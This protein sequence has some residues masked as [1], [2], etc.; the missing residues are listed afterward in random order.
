[1]RIYTLFR[2][3]FLFL[4]ENGIPIFSVLF[5]IH[6][7]LMVAFPCSCSELIFRYMLAHI[8]SYEGFPMLRGGYLEDQKEGIH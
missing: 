8:K 3:L 6:R 5:T 1:M 2:L 4:A 7:T